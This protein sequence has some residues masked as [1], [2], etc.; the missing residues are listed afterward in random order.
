MEIKQPA[1]SVGKTAEELFLDTF[2]GDYDDDAPWS[3]VTE[4]RRRNS[5]DVFKLAINYSR[6]WVPLERARAL[7]VL[8]QMDA[9]KPPA[10]R[11]HLDQSVA[12]AEESLRDNDPVVV[13]SAAWALSHLGNDRAIS[14]LILLRDHPDPDVRWA[15]AHGVVGTGSDDAIHTLVGL[16]KDSDDRVRDWATFGLGTQR[17]EDSLEIRNALHDR[18]NDTFED[19]RSEAIWGLARRKDEKGLRIL[20]DRLEAD[21]CAGDEMAAAEILGVDYETPA[22]NLS[23]GLRS[24]L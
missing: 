2:Q 16:T 5:P 12:L 24:L 23:V 13:R 11:S 9:D 14:A 4:L 19:A 6:S 20:L 1:Q 18:L 21:H 10:E 17:N 15:V 7:D 3:A 22:K 8:A